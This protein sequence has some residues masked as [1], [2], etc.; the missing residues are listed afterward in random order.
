MKGLLTKQKTHPFDRESGGAQRHSPEKM[1]LEDQL[2]G[3][4]TDREPTQGHHTSVHN[5]PLNNETFPNK[6]KESW[7]PQ[8]CCPWNLRVNRVDVQDNAETLT[9]QVSIG[10]VNVKEAV[11]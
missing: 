2:S 7:S 1:P 3:N 11:A 5:L 4:R 8:T 10:Q 9:K 6:F